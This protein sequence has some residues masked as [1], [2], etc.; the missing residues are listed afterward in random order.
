MH[1][2]PSCYGRTRN[3]MSMSMSMSVTASLTSAG[4]GKRS[5]GDPLISTLTIDSCSFKSLTV[6]RVNTWYLSVSLS[7]SSAISRLYAPYSE[8]RGEKRSH[9]GRAAFSL[10]D[11]NL[12]LLAITVTTA[13]ATIRQRTALHYR[14]YWQFWCT[15]WWTV[16]MSLSL[17]QPTLDLIQ[18]FISGVLDAEIE[19]K[20]IK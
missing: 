20:K 9:P 1:P 19:L 17:S 13:A 3:T 15:V 4:I 6:S 11:C 8:R 2:W 12:S 14:P 5:W 18:C 7:R 16:T 10:S